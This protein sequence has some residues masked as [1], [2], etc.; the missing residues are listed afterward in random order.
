MIK[1]L[2]IIALSTLMMSLPFQAT[3]QDDRE[4]VEKVLQTPTLSIQGTRVRISGAEGMV[5]K[6]YNLTGVEVSSVRIEGTEVQINLSHLPKGYY[7]VKIDKIVRKI[8][9]R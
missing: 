9:I 2:Q 8:T 1:V 5:M 7:I 4:D 6:V 3:A